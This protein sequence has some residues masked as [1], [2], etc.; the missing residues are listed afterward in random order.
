[1]KKKCI[2]ATESLPGWAAEAGHEVTIIEQL[3][4][5]TWTITVKKK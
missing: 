1:M 4:E 2:V 5:S 3:S